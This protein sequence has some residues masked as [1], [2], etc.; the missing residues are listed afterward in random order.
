MSRLSNKTVASSITINITT[1]INKRPRS[2]PLLINVY[3]NIKSIQTTN[4]RYSQQWCIK[5]EVCCGD[6][7]ELRRVASEAHNMMEN[8][9]SIWIVI[10]SVHLQQTE[11]LERKLFIF[12]LWFD[13]SFSEYQ[14]PTMVTNDHYVLITKRVKQVSF[15]FSW[16]ISTQ[17]WKKYSYLHD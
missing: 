5:S 2:R 17:V 10:F 3:V 1:S 16:S 4:R 15:Y 9:L 13:P 7:W 12:H 8:A 11:I 6:G 14:Y